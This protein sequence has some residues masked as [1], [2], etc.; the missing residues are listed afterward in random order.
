M[1][2][3][4][5]VSGGETEL[6]GVPKFLEKISDKV[7]WKRAFPAVKK[8]GPKPKYSK[9]MTLRRDERGATGRDLANKIKKR[10]RYIDKNDYSFFL[11]IDDTDCTDPD[12]KNVLF[13]NIFKKFGY[14]YGTHW[15][16]LWALPEIETWFLADPENTFQ[17]HPDLK[18]KY[19]CFI[20]EIRKIYEFENPEDFNFIL[21]N[22]EKC[23]RKLSEII[24]DCYKYCEIEYRKGKHSADL[25]SW[26]NPHKIADR[27]KYFRMYYYQIIKIITRIERF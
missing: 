26:V 21:R 17:K 25:L 20:Q 19:V 7:E 8:P 23:K 9:Q 13:E 5:F 16:G 14:K 24:Q 15:L 1:V 22:T 2:V 18:N 12:K 10:L 27:C 11:V 4:Y 6:R 3:G